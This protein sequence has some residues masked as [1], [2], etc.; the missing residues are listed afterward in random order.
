MVSGNIANSG[1]PVF[2]RSDA[3]SYGGIISGAGNLPQQAA[4]TPP[5]TGPRP[6]PRPGPARPIARA[7]FEWKLVA[8]ASALNAPA[9]AALPIALTIAVGVGV[10]IVLAVFVLGKRRGRKRSTVV[11]IR[12]I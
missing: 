10:V 6:D 7:D 8:T 9:E 2:N 12:R 11:E 5:L 3:V 1:S 4:S